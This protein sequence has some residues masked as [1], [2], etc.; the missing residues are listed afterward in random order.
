[1]SWSS[2]AAR[3]RPRRSTSLLVGGLTALLVGLTAAAAPA[4]AATAVT[5]TSTCNNALQI[6]S[7]GGQYVFEACVSVVFDPDN[8]TPGSSYVSAEVTVRRSE[9]TAGSPDVAITLS[10]VVL[11]RAW[12]ATDTTWEVAAV[13]GFVLQGTNTVSWSVT[14]SSS[15]SRSIGRYFRGCV[16]WQVA[17][18]SNQTTCTKGVLLS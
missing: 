8:W 10:N 9:A 13:P 16:V 6:L 2:T 5:A 1:M 15:V 3:I 14:Q 7:S 17:N 18:L 11:Y 4:Q 12:T